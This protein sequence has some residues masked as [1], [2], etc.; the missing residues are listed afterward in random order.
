[1]DGLPG[2]LEPGRDYEQAR[3]SGFRVIHTEENLLSVVAIQIDG[4]RPGWVVLGMTF[5]L[6]KDQTMNPAWL[7][8]MVGQTLEHGTEASEE[9][10][11]MY[12]FHLVGR[13]MN[14]Q[15]GKFVPGPGFGTT[16]G[17]DSVIGL[18]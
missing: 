1:M 17:H 10:A 8:A 13:C 16:T 2:G 7:P 15:F 6:G 18:N 9:M 11:R 4:D 14:G 12:F 5:P 3:I